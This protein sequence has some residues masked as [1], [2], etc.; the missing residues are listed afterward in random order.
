M[1]TLI[2]E[3]I[4][5]GINAV[6]SS[7]ITQGVIKQAVHYNHVGVIS[8]YNSFGTSS[9]TDAGVGLCYVSLTYAFTNTN[10]FIS[11]SAAQYNNQAYPGSND[12]NG[13]FSAV[14]TTTLNYYAVTSDNNANTK[15]DF[16][17][18]YAFAFGSLA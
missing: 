1:S 16:T 5:D 18:V 17:H 13:E 12:D 9:I 14:G 11:G 7:A 8:T 10:Y 2:V 3:K 4:S 15:L 6:Q